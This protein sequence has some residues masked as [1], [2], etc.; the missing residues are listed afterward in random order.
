MQPLLPVPPTLLKPLAKGQLSAASQLEK[1]PGSGAT[2]GAFLMSPLDCRAVHPILN[3]P[4]TLSYLQ[5]FHAAI[6]LNGRN[7]Q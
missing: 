4:E 7:G 6:L 3:M 5:L 1:V 2:T